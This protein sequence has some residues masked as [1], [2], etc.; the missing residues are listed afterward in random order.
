M[1]NSEMRL[2]LNCAVDNPCLLHMGYN[3]FFV[4]SIIYLYIFFLYNY[5]YKYMFSLYIYIYYINFRTPIYI[6]FFLQQYI[7]RMPF[8][9]P[10]PKA[11]RKAF[12]NAKDIA[13]IRRATAPVLQRANSRAT[14]THG[15][16]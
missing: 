15:Q 5:T 2:N 14:A 4:Q 9:K 8:A 6:P 13:T 1:P 11:C 12:R 3:L 7:Q 10:S 16:A